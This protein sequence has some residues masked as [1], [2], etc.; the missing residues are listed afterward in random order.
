MNNL[1][2]YNRAF[3]DLFSLKKEDLGVE[4]LYQ[5]VDA[6]DSVGHMELIAK[7]ES[8]FDIMIEM[9]DVID[10]SSYEKGK[11]ILQKY[12]VEFH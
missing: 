1:E 12:K 5:S 10:F 3:I 7:L 6:W 11:S 2:K 8:D 9:D 4:L